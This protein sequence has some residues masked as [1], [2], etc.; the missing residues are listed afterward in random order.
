MRILFGQNN[1][2][3]NLDDSVQPYKQFNKEL[4]AKRRDGIVI[5]SPIGIE[6]KSQIEEKARKQ[7]FEK[8]LKDIE[9]FMMMHGNYDSN[10]S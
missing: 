2:Y 7:A 10:T 6:Q 1:V 4:I 9:R 3:A 8:G 5:Q